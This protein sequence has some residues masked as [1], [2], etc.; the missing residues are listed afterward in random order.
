MR[1]AHTVG[2]ITLCLLLSGCAG[3]S[4]APP[5]DMRQ[6]VYGM[7]D[8]AADALLESPPWSGD[9]QNMV[10]M[11]APPTIDATFNISAARLTETLGRALLALEDGPQVLDWTPGMMTDDAPDNHWILES[12][13]NSNGVIRLSDRELLPYQWEITLRRPGQKAPSWRATLSGALDASAL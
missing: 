10:V 3:L 7:S 9:T 4:E 6:A 2:I 1:R 11:L 8:Q 5:D 12:H 13:L